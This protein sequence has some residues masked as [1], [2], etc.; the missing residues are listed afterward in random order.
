MCIASGKV[1]ALVKT[2]L[3]GRWKKIV[4]YAIFKIG[5]FSVF[6]GLYF[7]TA[8]LGSFRRILLE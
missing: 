3:K 2:I 7:E 4:L 6:C 5:I 8:H 1:E